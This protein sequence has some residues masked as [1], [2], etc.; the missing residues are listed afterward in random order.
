MNFRSILLYSSAHFHFIDI[1]WVSDT[2]IREIICNSMK[3]SNPHFSMVGRWKANC[4]GTS[5]NVR[6]HGAIQ[7]FR[8][9]FCRQKG[10]FKENDCYWSSICS[11]DIQIEE[12]TR[13]SA[14]FD[15][16]SYWYFIIKVINFIQFLWDFQCNS[17]PNE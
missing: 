5:C 15:W 4:K 2:K 13:Y 17:H 8:S 7:K 1:K 16:N 6:I 12:G 10:Y 11:H 14:W 9:C 3:H